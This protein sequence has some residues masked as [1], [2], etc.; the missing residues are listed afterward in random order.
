[1]DRYAFHNYDSNPRA[2]RKKDPRGTP[3]LSASEQIEAAINAAA[4]GD[5]ANLRRDY[6]RGFDMN[7]AD[8]DGRT[9]MILN[10]FTI[11]KFFYVYL[12]I[13]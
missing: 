3:A 10:S 13:P 7:M 4:R 12:N 11:L 8:Y 2:T 5:L 6:L 1:M 9:R